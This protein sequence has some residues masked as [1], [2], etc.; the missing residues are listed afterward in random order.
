MRPMPS[1]L[2]VAAALSAALSAQIP[3]RAEWEITFA[4][5]EAAA[6]LSDLRT[7][8]PKTFE[9]RLMERPWSATGPVPFLR[10]VRRDGAVTAQLF[11]FWT[12]G[13]IAPVQRPRGADI[14]CR[15]GVCVRPIDIK[16]Q[17]DWATVIAS[18]ASQNA[19]PTKND[20]GVVMVCADCDHLWIKTAVEGQ[21]RE[22]S[23]NAPGSE[24][25]ARSLLQLMQRSA[26]AAGY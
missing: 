13:T 9:A 15:D 7:A 3:E 19:C 24:T 16:E 21:Y 10:L 6:G 23:C 4:Q 22:Q 25:S 11:V 8:V 17:R 5:V 14:M 2:S 12:P 20:P 18:L 26:R 1:L